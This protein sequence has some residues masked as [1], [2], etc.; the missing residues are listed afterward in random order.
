MADRST[1]TVDFEKLR[2]TVETGVRLQDNV[3][4]ATP[5]FLPENKKQALG[6]RRVGLGVK[7]GRHTS[8]L[9]SRGHLVCRLLLGKIQKYFKRHKRAALHSGARQMSSLP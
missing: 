3:I 6:E 4:D 5:Y 8:E 9:Q 1:K 2:Q 7:I